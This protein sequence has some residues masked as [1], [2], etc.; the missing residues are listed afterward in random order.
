MAK[1]PQRDVNPLLLNLAIHLPKHLGI[2]GPKKV[3]EPQQQH[4]AG[5]TMHAAKVQQQQ[6]RREGNDGLSRARHG[7]RSRVK[8]MHEGHS[9]DSAGMGMEIGMQAQL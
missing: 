1:Q 3:S 5:T 6:L 4:G 7:S 8:T 9:G 2:A